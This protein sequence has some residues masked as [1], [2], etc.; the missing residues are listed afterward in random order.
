MDRVQDPRQFAQ[1]GANEG[2]QRRDDTRAEAA[3]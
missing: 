1:V 2:D 3:E